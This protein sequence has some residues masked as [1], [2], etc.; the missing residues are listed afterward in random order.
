MGVSV[1]RADRGKKMKIKVAILRRD[2]TY[3][4]RLVSAFNSRY[5]EKLEMYSFMQEQ[6]ALEALTASR[7]DMLPFRES[8]KQVNPK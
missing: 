7:I 6:A 4:S 3:L 2:K 5:T 1:K 8:I